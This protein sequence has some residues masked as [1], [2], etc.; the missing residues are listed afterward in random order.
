MQAA[1][2]T[3]LLAPA[4]DWFAR[5]GWQPFSFQREVWAAYLRGE[6]GL[7]HAATGA[8]KT[9]AAW[10]GPLLRP[11]ACFGSRR[12]ARWPPTPLRH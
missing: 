5:R 3:D 6:S 4:L 12:Y 7:I 8:G 10:M 11:C 9:Y 2:E 1:T